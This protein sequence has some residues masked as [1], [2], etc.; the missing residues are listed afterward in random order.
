MFFV[1]GCKVEF[2]RKDNWI[3]INCRFREVPVEII[4]PKIRDFLDKHHNDNKILSISKEDEYEVEIDNGVDLKFDL[5]FN[6]KG[7]DD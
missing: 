3:E 6:F 1:Y 7:Y 4:P 5:K 2:D